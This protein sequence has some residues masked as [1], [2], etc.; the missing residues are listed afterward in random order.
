MSDH[1]GGDAASPRCC[2]G[3]PFET[4]EPRQPAN[5]AES[6]AASPG[7]ISVCS[8]GLVIV[9]AHRQFDRLLEAVALYAET[10]DIMWIE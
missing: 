1:D 8:L 6:D 4:D 2:V 7:L 5:V 3:R 9:G 10:H